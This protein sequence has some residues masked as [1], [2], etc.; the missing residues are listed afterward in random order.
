MYEAQK[1]L[2]L[3]GH[4]LRIN[5]VVADAAW[6]NKLSPELKGI[7]GKAMDEVVTLNNE[8]TLKQ[9]K[10]MPDELK[11]LGRDR[12]LSDPPRDRA[13]LTLCSGPNLFFDL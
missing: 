6:Y 11:K 13:P 3:T 8:L 7:I 12:A 5:V 10:D 4:M 9:E 1:Y 2:M